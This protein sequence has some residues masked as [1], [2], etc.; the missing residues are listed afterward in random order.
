[1][2]NYNLAMQYNLLS[3]SG[4]HAKDNH[5]HT[6]GYRYFRKCLGFFNFLT[7]LGNHSKREKVD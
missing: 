3:K 5:Y 1:M 6:L 2:P 7:P 4:M